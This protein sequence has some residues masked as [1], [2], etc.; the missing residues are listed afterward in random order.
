MSTVV[1]LCDSCRA[2]IVW[3]VTVNRKHMP[4]NAETVSDGDRIFDASKH[5]SHFA[6]CPNA[7]RHRKPR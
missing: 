2:E 6:T 7:H 5:T 4:V 3:L 1:Q